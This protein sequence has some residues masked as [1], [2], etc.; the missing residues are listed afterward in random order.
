MSLASY[1]TAPPRVNFNIVNNY[2]INCQALTQNP[3]S[4]LAFCKRLKTLLL[5]RVKVMYNITQ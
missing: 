3:K 1:R 5:Y 4:D 2:F